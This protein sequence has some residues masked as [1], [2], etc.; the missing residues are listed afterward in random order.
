MSKEELNTAVKATPFKAF[1]VRLAD[2]TQYQIPSADHASLS[3]SGRTLVVFGDDGT[4][5]IDV[6]LILEISTTETA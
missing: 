1:A 5:L 6:A 3:P 4:R 2:G